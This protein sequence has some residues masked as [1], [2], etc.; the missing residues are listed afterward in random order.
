MLFSAIRRL[1]TLLVIYSVPA[2]SSPIRIIKAYQP[3][4]ALRRDFGATRASG[5]DIGL[6][7]VALLLFLLAGTLA[8][9]A[10]QLTGRVL[11]AAS[12][13]PVAFA[14]V[15]IKGKALG[16]TANASGHFA[17]A[18]PA[19]LP[20]VDSV[21]ISCVGFRAL[22][23][24][25]GQ[26]RRGEAAWRLL[27]QSQT[28]GEVQVRHSQLRPAILGR[29]EVGGL[30]YWTTNSRDTSE[31]VATDERGRELATLLSVRKNCY[32]DTFRFHVQQN[33]FK[34]I[35]FRFKLYEMVDDRPGRQ[36]LTDDIQFTLASQQTGW[37]SLYLHAYNIQ[38][39]KGQTVAVG[40]QWLHGERLAP[41]NGV[42]GGQAAFPSVGHR[43]LVRK[44]SE[45]DWR[46]FPMNLSMYLAV[47][48][49]D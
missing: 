43:A 21:I 44:K 39:R 12:D 6:I 31:T 15:G 16:S 34:A 23:L 35:R 2:I 38:L 10:Q 48:Q 37:I 20:D 8:S 17:F 7:R 42:F 33:D 30:A 3:V 27:P 26:L 24:T 4:D 40:F 1:N 13:Q 18:V 28:L 22:R 47:Q 19:A 46:I 32:L 5:R 49:H 14:T 36:L 29:K 45:A 25:V 9:A 41:E 11:A